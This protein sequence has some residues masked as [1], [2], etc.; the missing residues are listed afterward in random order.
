MRCIEDIVL[1]WSVSYCVSSNWTWG[2][3]SMPECNTASKGRYSALLSLPSSSLFHLF[4]VIFLA[5][6]ICCFFLLNSSAS[7]LFYSQQMIN[8]CVIS[9]NEV[10]WMHVWVLIQYS[11]HPFSFCTTPSTSIIFVY[12]TLPTLLFFSVPVAKIWWRSPWMCLCAACSQ[13]ATKCGS[14]AKTA[15]CWIT[16]NPQNSAAQNWRAGG[17]GA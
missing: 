2:F 14:R 10:L 9:F 12:S 7:H 3:H 16:S 1:L 4:P 15:Q 5:V 11:F 13:I 8:W 6:Q 17:N